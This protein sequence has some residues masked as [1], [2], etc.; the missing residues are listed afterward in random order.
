MRLYA[1]QRVFSFRTVF[2]ILDSRG[3]VR[4]TVKGELLSLTKKLHVFDSSGREVALLRGKIIS[5]LPTYDIYIGNRKAARIVKRL[6]L[7]RPSYVITDCNWR[8]EGNLLQH[9]YS[10][11]NG[12]RNRVATISK[13][14]MSIGD[15]F[16]LDVPD[17]ENEVLAV[18]MMLAI[19]CVMDDQEAS[20]LTHRQTLNNNIE[21]S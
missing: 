9:S 7:F 8:V 10:L 11:Y 4:Y 2:N 12:R 3:R 15:C 21:E 20:S 6:T 1:R 18:C 13:R 14:W 17:P 16:E 5:L 19:D